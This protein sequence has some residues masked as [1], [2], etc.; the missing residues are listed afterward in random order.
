MLV[1][2]KASHERVR[3]QMST[4]CAD[5]GRTPVNTTD[6]ARETAASEPAVIHLGRLSSVLPRGLLLLGETVAVPGILLYAFVAAGHSMAGLVAVFLWRSACIGGRG[7]ARISV[8]ATCWMTFALF[9]SRTVAGL[10]VSSVTLYLVVPVVLCAA[11]ALFFLFSARAKRPFLM[12]LAT[13][14]TDDI[15]DS[16]AL[17]GL[18]A[19]LS[20][21]WGGTHLICAAVG[22]WAITLPPTQAVA[23]TSV[24]AMA[25]AVASAGACI[26]WG[27]WRV[28]RIPGLRIACCDKPDVSVLPHAVEDEPVAQAA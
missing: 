17:R 15:P 4:R 26:A 23:V 8:P 28:R 12:R 2:G 27:L 20:G 10:A 3:R 9:V 13:D 19:Q 1:T 7:V 5:G 24:L 16:P 11:Q 25:C 14:Y 22:A 18:F 6:L 21:I